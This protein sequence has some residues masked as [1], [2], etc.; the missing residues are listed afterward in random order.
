M[1]EFGK[2]TAGPQP[3]TA[4]LLTFSSGNTNQNT[5]KNTTYGKL[6]P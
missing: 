1:F 5:K 6:L 3:L 2:I 4:G